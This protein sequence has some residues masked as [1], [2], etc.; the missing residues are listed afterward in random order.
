MRFWRSKPVPGNPLVSM[1]VAAYVVDEPRRRAAL[2]C[3]LKSF[4][5]QTH[6]N[7]EAVVVHDGPGLGS[8]AN[9]DS[10]I[11]LI[12]TQERKQ[13]FGHPWRQ[14]GIEKT[15]GKYVGMTNGDNYYAPAYFEA[16]LRSLIANN[17]D[18]IHCDMIHSHKIWKPL[19]TKLK[20]GQIDLG[21]WLASGDLV[22]ST[23]WKD[24]SFA[25]D[26]TYIQE[27]TRKAGKVVKLSNFMFVHN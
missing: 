12:E 2:E 16:M 3:L 10:R 23:P 18:F 9:L 5:A 15:R 20:R 1:V 11:H 14:F 4:E 24:I 6:S 13:N 19:P 21:C 7:W 25:A 27:L 22:R 17:A 26:W 8:F